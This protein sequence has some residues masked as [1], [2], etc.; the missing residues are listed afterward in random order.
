MR[1]ASHEVGLVAVRKGVEMQ[2][3]ALQWARLVSIEPSIKEGQVWNALKQ[4]FEV[5]LAIAV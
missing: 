5:E 1:P 3:K 2:S 4:A